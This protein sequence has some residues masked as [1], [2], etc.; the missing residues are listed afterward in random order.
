MSK[1]EKFSICF[2]SAGLAGGGMER[3][4]TN[5]ANH[6]ASLGHHVTILNLF[7]T[8]IFFDLHKDIN[9]VWPS[10]DRDRM[11]RLMYAFRL[12]PYIRK[13]LKAIQPDTVLSFG[14]WFNGYVIL[15]TRFTGI[16][17]YVSD[18]M[19]PMLNMGFLLETSRSLLYRYASGIISQTNI[20]SEI[21]KKK[22]K[23]SNIVVIPNPVKVID[24]KGSFIKK[25]QIVTVG[26]LSREKG[27]TILLKAF[28]KA[29]VSDWTLHIVG[30][31]KERIKL[32][33]EATDLGIDRRT[34]F[35]GHMKNFDDI[36]CESEIFI[37]PSL[38][39]GFPNALIEAMSVPLACISSD[40]IAGPSDIVTDRVNGLLV[41]PEN[42]EQ[43]SKCIDL[44][45]HDIGLRNKLAS[46]AIEIRET[47]EFGKIASKYLNFITNN[48]RS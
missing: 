18:R 32:E 12:I 47:L 44:L 1:G 38:Y 10:L 13:S 16:P 35:Y 5:I 42:V 8:D 48:E 11:H 34:F 24:S 21:L 20:A 14:E 23:A 7:K 45:I 30:D 36:L 28:A 27:H 43:L 6:A 29:T 37:L 33:K 39:E 40:C 41:E 46:K 17:I 31:G 3:S 2:V 9:I 4:L 22:T 19:G 26:R 25:K 15:A